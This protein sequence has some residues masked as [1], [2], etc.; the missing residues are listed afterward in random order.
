V[1]ILSN[2]RGGVPPPLMLIYRGLPPIKLLL[3]RAFLKNLDFVTYTYLIL[4]IK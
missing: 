4:I 3:F 1:L 2:L